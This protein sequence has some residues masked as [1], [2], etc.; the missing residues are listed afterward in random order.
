MTSSS[1]DEEQRPEAEKESDRAAHDAGEERG[2]D[3]AAVV[4]ESEPG[5]LRPYEPEEKELPATEEHKQC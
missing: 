1:R 3:R 2:A 5:P 4:R